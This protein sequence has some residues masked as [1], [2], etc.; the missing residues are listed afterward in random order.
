MY[1]IG[2]LFAQTVL[3]L[4]K[5]GQF[6]SFSHREIIFLELHALFK[7]QYLISI[8]ETKFSTLDFSYNSNFSLIQSKLYNLY[9]VTSFKHEFSAE[10]NISVSTDNEHTSKPTPAL[11]INQAVTQNQ[12]F[13]LC[14]G[15]GFK[16][17]KRHLGVEHGLTEGEYRKLFDLPE[18]MPLVAP[19]YSD[20]KAA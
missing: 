4:N 11:P 2:N 7:N 6:N 12:V 18:S 5:D 9:L 10:D 8:A 20:K 14:C 3:F 15:K 13:C 19:S 1:L 17:I 16:M